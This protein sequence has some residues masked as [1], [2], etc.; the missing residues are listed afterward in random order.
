MLVGAAFRRSL[1][2]GCRSMSS[3]ASMPAGPSAVLQS[4]SLM[5]RAGAHARIA[6][7]LSKARLSS[8]VVMT[9]GA[10]F[11]MGSGGIMD[12]GTFACTA[13]G[14]ALASASANT[15]NQCLERNLDALMKRTKDRPLPSGRISL[16]PAVAFAASTGISSFLLLHSTVN[17]LAATLALSNIFLYGFIYTPLKQKT[18]ANT[19]IGAVVGAIP[20]LIGWA[21]ATGTVSIEAAILGALLFSWQ[22]PHFMSLAWLSRKDYSAGGYKM[23]PSTNEKGAAAVALRHSVYLL[24]INAAAVYYSMATLPFLAESTLLNAAMI[25]F[26]YKF[27]RNPDHASALNLFKLSLVYLPI[28]LGFMILHKP[29]S[30]TEEAEVVTQ[31]TEP[32]LPM[33]NVFNLFPCPLV[34]GEDIKVT[35]RSL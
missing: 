11:V 22:M 3:A 30:E 21:G 35:R 7:E 17:P 34:N 28:L 6:L 33:L 16:G 29:A 14:T 4:P 31:S 18:I 12:W 20:P 19:W 9:G 13:A 15:I 2:Q 25:F 27:W 8:L 10:G 1:A 32:M 26:S 24:A 5:R 23:M